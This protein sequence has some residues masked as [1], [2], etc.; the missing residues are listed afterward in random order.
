MKVLP[1]AFFGAYCA[2]SISTLA[3]SGAL[4]HRYSF[5][6]NTGDSVGVADGVLNGGATVANGLLTLNGTT[7]FVTLP[8]NL[9]SNYNSVT[10]ETW[11]TDNG[12]GN[13]ARIFDFG[14]NTGG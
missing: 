8:P 9:V 7:G 4:T 14:N 6:S 1:L 3:Q 11:V 10:F 12:S 13:W 5:N 2:V